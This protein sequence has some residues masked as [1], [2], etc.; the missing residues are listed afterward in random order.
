M[1]K[2]ISSLLLFA[3]LMLA[4]PAVA[5]SVSFG[6]K[7]G[8]NN[9][10]MKFDESVF[11]SDNR[12]GF[13]AGPVLKVALPVGGLGFDIAALYD[14]RDAKVNDETIKQKSILVPLNARLNLGIGSAAGIYVAAG[15]QFGFNIGDDQFTW[16]SITKDTENARKEAENT[17]QLKKSNF[18]VNLGAGVYLSKNLEF[19]FTY[20][21]AM[22]KT[23]DATFKEAV[24]TATHKDDAKAKAWTISAAYYF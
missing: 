15:P 2:M 12:F 7:A 13:F 21:I 14:Q 24:E 22:G 4:V 11:D 5:Q 17:F 1:K 16:K 6:V 8:L 23:A 9:N 20:N 19:G 10:E 18:S 3:A